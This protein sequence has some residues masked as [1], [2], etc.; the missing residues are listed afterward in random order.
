MVIGRLDG[1]EVTLLNVYAPPGAKW[2]FYK[3]IFDLMTSKGKG[4]IICGGDYN[5]RLNP[6]KDVSGTCHNPNN[7]KNRKIPRR[8]VFTIITCRLIIEFDNTVI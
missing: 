3:H 4:I 2:A 8:T 7:A 1:V 6:M 5:L